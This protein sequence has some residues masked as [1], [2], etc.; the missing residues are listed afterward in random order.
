M[1]GPTWMNEWEE[2]RCFFCQKGQIIATFTHHAMSVGEI[3]FSYLHPTLLANTT[4]DGSRSEGATGYWD[5][6]NKTQIP[7]RMRLAWDNFRRLLCSFD[8]FSMVT[9]GSSHAT[10]QRR[11]WSNL[12]WKCK[13]MK[14]K[15]MSASANLLRGC[16]GGRVIRFDDVVW[17]ENKGNGFWLRAKAEVQD[18]RGR[19]ATVSYTAAKLPSSFV[20][21]SH[22]SAKDERQE[23]DWFSSTCSSEKVTTIS[24]HFFFFSTSV[25]F[26]SHRS[27]QAT[28]NDSPVTSKLTNSKLLSAF[29]HSG[30]RFRT[31]KR[32]SICTLSLFPSLMMS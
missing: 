11:E 5:H 22:V 16:C 21:S 6:E 9:E 3:K 12:K 15:E 10:K 19:S 20:I 27:V 28:S 8:P 13:A 14:R 32:V 4:D 30:I 7:S 1:I 2:D 29:F 18:E 26:L 17:R 24:Q 25:V 31:K 23:E